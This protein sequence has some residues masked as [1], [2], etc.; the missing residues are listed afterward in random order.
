MKNLPRKYRCTGFTLIEIMIVV[1]LIGV[2][3]AI[4]IPSF[5]KATETSRAKSCSETLRKLET[6][7]EQ[8]ALETRATAESTPTAADLI[9][10]YLLGKENSMPQCPSGG[11]YS[12]NNMSNPPTCSIGTNGT[13]DKNDDHVFD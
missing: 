11:T 8:W 3:M 9:S 7:K 1:M 6:A 5:Q 10:E 4:A 2:L 12:L 13:P